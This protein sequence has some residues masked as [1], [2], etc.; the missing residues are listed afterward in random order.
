M[1]KL[2]IEGG[3]SLKG[4]IKIS[5]SKNSALPLMIASLLTDNKV[6]LHN[7][8]RLK[9]IETTISIIEFLGKKVI[10]E[11]KST[12]VITSNKEPYREG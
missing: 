9:D 2:I 8:P 1:E 3:K 11:D 4:S 12:V 5:G 10:W 6:I 7:V